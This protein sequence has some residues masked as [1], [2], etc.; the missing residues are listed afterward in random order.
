MRRLGVASPA[1][2]CRR[3]TRQDVP[4]TAHLAG[5]RTRLSAGGTFCWGL[6]GTINLQGGV[7]F[8]LGAL[9]VGGWA[10]SAGLNSVPANKQGPWNG[11]VCVA[12]GVGGCGYAGPANEQAEGLVRRCLF[13][14][15]RR[16][17][18]GERYGCLVQYWRRISVWLALQVVSA[19]VGAIAALG[20]GIIC[21]G[22]VMPAWRC[23]VPYNR[24]VARHLFGGR[25]PSERW[26][27]FTRIYAAGVLFVA[28][29]Y[30]LV[31]GSIRSMTA[32]VIGIR[33]QRE[34]LRTSA[35]SDQRAR[36]DGLEGWSS[37]S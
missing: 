11:V 14:W 1:G 33:R 8:Q 34:P 12:D 31:L 3:A 17:G 22:L 10:R 29:V 35:G 28:G 4:T 36:P 7:S 5:S 21:L 15:R 23:L 20:F 6:C 19:R 37:S 24:R 32:T 26:E 25:M 30:C 16:S 27:R 9:G 13:R 18:R 2:Q